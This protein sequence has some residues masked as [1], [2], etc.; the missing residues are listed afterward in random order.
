M[1]NSPYIPAR[2]RP[3]ALFSE[4]FRKKET[5]I[6][7]M[8]NTQ[9]VSR[10]AKPHRMASSIRPQSEEPPPAAVVSAATAVPE[11][12]VRSISKSQYCIG[13]QPTSLHTIHST[14]PLRLAEGAV[15]TTFCAMVA[16]CS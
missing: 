1:M 3:R 8:G 11:A 7:T 4:P 16:A 15:R 2:N 13:V 14:Y 9:G 10:A 6:G 12:D 5:V